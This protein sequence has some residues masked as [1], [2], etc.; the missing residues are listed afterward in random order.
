M[1]TSECP[2]KAQISQGPGPF[3]Q[4]ELLKTGH[5]AAAVRC[6]RRCCCRGSCFRCPLALSLFAFSRRPCPALVLDIVVNLSKST[7][8]LAVI[9][10]RAILDNTVDV[11]VCTWTC[12]LPCMSPQTPYVCKPARGWEG[13]DASYYI[14]Q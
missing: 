14:M 5:T 2:L 1:F 13:R 6:C 7:V 9:V 12:A 10:A 4:I 8:V 3:F 11:D